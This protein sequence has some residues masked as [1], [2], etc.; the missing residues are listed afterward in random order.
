MSHAKLFG[1]ALWG[2]LLLLGCTGQQ[3]VSPDTV[4]LSIKNDSSKVLRVDR[5]NYV[6]ILLGSEVKSRYVIEGDAKATLTITRDDITVS[7]ESLTDAQ[8]NAEE[9]EPFKVTAK[10]LQ[11][12]MSE[13]PTSPPSNYSVTLSLGCSPED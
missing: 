9:A 10:Q 7:F 3:Y 4:E 5:C 12:D 2:A 8:G 11:T 1:P 6:P 13:S